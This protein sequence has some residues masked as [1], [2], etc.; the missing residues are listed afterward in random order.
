[1]SV[2]RPQVGSTITDRGHDITVHDI[3]P[4]LIVRVDGADLPNFYRTVQGARMAAVRH[5]DQIEKARREAAA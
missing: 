4:D 3:T 1:M 5:I 2:A